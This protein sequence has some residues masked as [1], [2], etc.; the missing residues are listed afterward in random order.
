[1]VATERTPLATTGEELIGAPM[2]TVASTFFSRL[3]ARITN[4]PRR[5]PMKTLPSATSGD[6]QMSP[7]ISC[8]QQA[9]PVA[10]S[11]QW[12][13]LPQSAMNTS[14]SCT[15]GVELVW[16]RSGY[17]QTSPLCVM[18]PVLVAS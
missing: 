2:S 14:P 3:A 7:C 8:V 16:L 15:A 5:V 13:V 1:M 9:R 12:I 4:S 11:T 10:A 6:A 17:D 18:S